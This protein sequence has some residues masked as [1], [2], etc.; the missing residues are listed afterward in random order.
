MPFILASSRI[1]PEIEGEIVYLD[2]TQKSGIISRFVG[3]DENI[4]IKKDS[5]SKSEKISTS[6][7]K[8]IILKSDE[9]VDT[10]HILR[11]AGFWGSKLKVY[12]Y[13]YIAYK[14]YHSERMDGYIVNFDDYNMIGS[15]TA[16][17]KFNTTGVVLFVKT[18][19]KEEIIELTTDIEG[20]VV[21]AKNKLMRKNFIKVLDGKCPEMEKVLEDK[22]YKVEDFVTMLEDYN[23]TCN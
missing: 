21:I 4:K 23:K 1:K 11:P 10:F 3:V 7:L 16:R 14:V 5:K 20:S 18:P 17:M 12:K 2:G 19:E 15:P 22:K 6:L 13:L 9:S 8:Y